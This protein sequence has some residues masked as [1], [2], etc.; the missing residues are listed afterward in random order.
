MRGYD[1]DVSRA[2][3]LPESELPKTGKPHN[4]LWDATITKNCFLLL[5]S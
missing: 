2:K 1:I 4:A 3:L 5:E